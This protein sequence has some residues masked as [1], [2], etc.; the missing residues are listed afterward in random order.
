MIVPATVILQNQVDNFDRET[1][2]N[3]M[4]KARFASHRNKAAAEATEK[5][6]EGEDR[7]NADNLRAM[8]DECFEE[9]INKLSIRELRKIIKLKQDE[10]KST[11][12]KNDW[13]SREESIE[14]QE[15]QDELPTN[16]PKNKAS[17]DN[18]NNKKKKNPKEQKRKKQ[19]PNTETTN[20]KGP[21]A[22]TKT[23]KQKHTVRF[24]GVDSKETENTKKKHIG[25]QD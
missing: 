8:M 4:L 7:V 19:P 17:N 1:T 25:D 3:Q 9:K 21:A 13:G 22:A 12:R 6:L 16:P 2:L 20:S 18:T 23:K 10:S 5:A 11:H 15:P 24:H 14:D